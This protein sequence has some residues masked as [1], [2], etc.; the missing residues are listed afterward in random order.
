MMD[1]ANR[2][3]ICAGILFGA[4]ISMLMVLV[5]LDA[6]ALPDVFPPPDT[7]IIVAIQLV[8]QVATVSA[9]SGGPPP[10]FGDFVFAA[11]DGPPVELGSIYECSVNQSQ[12]VSL[13]N[14][15]H[16]PYTGRHRDTEEK[17]AIF[18]VFLVYLGVAMCACA[19]PHCEPY[20]YSYQ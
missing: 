12:V 13:A 18:A 15:T 11:G 9:R 14:E 5:I 6:P 19:N 2:E 20:V 4:F 3:R 8:N 10:A 7:C 1:V 17:W 16:T